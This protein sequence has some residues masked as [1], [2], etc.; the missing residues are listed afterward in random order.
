MV[1]AFE[2]NKAETLTMLRTIRSLMKAHQL[3]DV[4]I[5]ADAG[6]VSEA[7]RE[8]I[9]DEHLSYIIG[10]RIPEVSWCVKDWRSRHSTVTLRCPR[11]SR[12][13]PHRG[14]PPMRRGPPVVG[15]R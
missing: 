10:A 9:E 11:T 15:T 2:G 1:E 5:V 8:A 4:T 14:R 12:S 7:D 3:E 13:S 6:M